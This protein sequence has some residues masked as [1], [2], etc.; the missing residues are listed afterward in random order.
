MIEVKKT[1]ALL[2]VAGMFGACND[3]P[4]PPAKTPAT[5]DKPAADAPK[6]GADNA[7]KTAGETP[8]AV[9][10]GGAPTSGDACTNYADAICKEAG[11]K[12]ATC[13]NFRQATGLMPAA[14]CTAGLADMAGAKTKIKALG[15]SCDQLIAK[16][17][18]DLGEKTATCELVRTKTKTFP[19]DRCK[20]ML[21]AEVYPQVIGELKAQE[22]QNQPLDAA[23][24]ASINA[25]TFPW[26][27][28]PWVWRYEFERVEI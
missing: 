15:A 16:L 3:A 19:P 28:N 11:E 5:P 23:K 12:T 27:S 10:Q 14:A 7:A 13:T 17:C 9:A 4:A 24:T 2:L 8:D 6:P 18:G 22:A 21:G 20:E 25:K 26:A 1:L